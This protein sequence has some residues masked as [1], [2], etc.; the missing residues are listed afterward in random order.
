MLG[1]GQPILAVVSDDLLVGEWAVSHNFPLHTTTADLQ[2]ILT[3]NAP[4]FLFSIVNETLVKPASLTLPRRGAINYHDSPL[5]RYAGINSTSWAIVNGEREHGVTWHLMTEVLDAGDILRQ[6]AVVIEPRETALSL[7]G[8]CYEAAAAEFS[9]LVDELELGTNL[10]SPQDLTQRTFY[11]RKKQLDNGGMVSWN[12]PVNRIDALVRAVDF[13]RYPNTLGTVKVVLPKEILVVS[14]VRA[15][16]LHTDR[17][18][19]DIAYRAPGTVTAI[20]TG[21]LV[22]ATL[23]GLVE[24]RAFTTLGGTIVALDDVVAR[25]GLNVGDRLTEPDG[26]LAPRFETAATRAASWERVWVE[27][28]QNLLPPSIPFGEEAL[29]VDSQQSASAGAGTLYAR[30]DSP[31]VAVE[32]PANFRPETTRAFGVRVVAMFAE[33]LGRLTGATEFDLAIS[34]PQLASKVR[35]LE[36]LVGGTLPWRFVSVAG[37]T[38][39]AAFRRAE[40]GL[41]E[42][43]SRGPFLLDLGARHRPLRAASIS[44]ATGSSATNSQ[45]S[46]RRNARAGAYLPISAFIVDDAAAGPLSDSFG[47]SLVVQ[48][49]LASCFLRYDPQLLSDENAQRIATLLSGFLGNTAESAGYNS[50]TPSASLTARTSVTCPTVSIVQSTVAITSVPLLSHA[51]VRDLGSTWN[52]SKRNYPST[53]TVHDLIIHRARMSPADTAVEENGSVLNFG[54]LVSRATALGV[55]LSSLGV[56]ENVIVGLFA[57][58]TSEMVV[59]LLGI[60]MARG[61][62]LPIDPDYPADRVRFMLGDAKVAIVL[63]QS[64]LFSRLPEFDGRVI[65]I[66]EPLPQAGEPSPEVGERCATLGEPTAVAASPDASHSRSLAYVIYTSGSTGAPKGVMVEH[67]GVV[68]YLSWCIPA[69]GLEAGRGAPVHSS[70]SFDLTVTSLLAPLAAGSKVVLAPESLGAEALANTLKA[71][72]DFALVKLTPS[73]L[74][75]LTQQIPPASASGRTRRFVVGGEALHGASLEFW[76]KHAPDTLIINEYGP[77][78]TVV[79]CCVYEATA[80][81]ISSTDVPIGFAIANTRLYVLDRGLQLLPP[82]VAGELYIGGAGVARGY[83]GRPKLTAERF[84]PD[85]F[86]DVPDARMYRTGDRVRMR[87]DGCLEFLGRFDDQVKIRGYRIELGEIEAALAAFPAVAE[88]AVIVQELSQGD[89]RLVGYYVPRVNSSQDEKNGQLD[90]DIFRKFLAKQLPSY[91][92]PTVYVPLSDLPLTQNGKLDRKRLPKAAM[93]TGTTPHNSTPPRRALEQMLARV[94]AEVL[95]IPLASI[96][97]ES[98]FF[99]LGGHSL[100]AVRMIA[101]VEQ[102]LHRRLPLTALLV[103]PALGEFADAIDAAEVVEDPLTVRLREGAGGVAPLF[104]FHGSFNSGGYYCHQLARELDENQPVFILRPFRP[105]GPVTMEEMAA[106]AALEIRATHPEGPYHLGGLCNGATLAFE[107]ARILRADGA[108]VGLLAMVNTTDRNPGFKSLRRMSSVLSRTIRLDSAQEVEFFRKTR[109][110]GVKVRHTWLRA[111]SQSDSRFGAVWAALRLTVARAARTVGV[112]VGGAMGNAGNAGSLAPSV[113]ARVPDSSPSTVADSGSEVRADVPAYH[114]EERY[115]SRATESYSPQRFDGPVE[116]IFWED[117]DALR[118]S[119]SLHGDDLT[120]GW[121]RVAELVSI[122]TIEGEN[123]TEQLRDAGKLGRLL[124]VLIAEANQ[125]IA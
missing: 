67:R 31:T 66:D 7:N 55:Y 13:G 106:Q 6:A 39:E 22:V 58:R 32:I 72:D 104:Y 78:E 86:A 16:G 34:T 100:L 54:D 101:Q 56:G 21:G 19:S 102:L 74:D 79:G 117:S 45:F 41:G 98:S 89:K 18:E 77:T 33:M 46:S 81:D 97:V 43:T 83:L 42:V 10:P 119:E 90:T 9:A 69:Y 26:E 118:D 11:G 123:R 37:E 122:R 103:H 71:H 12:W 3:A 73:H 40:A 2:G 44:V 24:F 28:L 120:R 62:Y 35:G 51:Q 64:W 17:G 27:R 36:D 110:Y 57:E 63:T 60:L 94:W 111:R 109:R 84:L 88:C 112:G 5:P 125:R 107:V 116:L 108:T 85:P 124:A 53:A 92:V 99:D 68:N 91:M 80:A 65:R 4:D 30:A 1:K 38:I 59:G 50:G 105:G 113:T 114:A 75:L 76:A 115:I 20:H 70:I 87:I 82:G 14:Q 121:G 8:K 15:S 47:L 52:E 61:A 49:D 48:S 25:N 96:G 29:S 95:D 93:F 23:D